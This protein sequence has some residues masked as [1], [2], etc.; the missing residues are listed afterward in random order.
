MKSIKNWDNKTWLSSKDY[1]NSFNKF[2]IKH[3]NLNSSSKILDIGCGRGKILGNLS[4]KLK[5]KNR[6]IGID[7]ESHKDK[8]KKIFFKK[9]DGINFFKANNKR[10]DLIL[11]KQTIHLLKMSE[12]KKLIKFCKNNLLPEGQIF[13]FTLDPVKNEIPTF[14][15][16]HQKLQYS[17][18]KDKKIINFIIKNNKCIS[19]KFI[20][21]VKVKKQ[22][23]L[24]MVKDKYISTLL[25]FNL[26][27]IEKGCEEIRLKFKNEINFRDKL[28]CVVIKK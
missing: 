2:L 17:L 23:Y 20:Y 4:T 25:D 9:I 15:K 1:I 5:L 16:M 3:S 6:P 11:I 19:K 10:F 27:D 13:I 18:N 26:K 7:I 24:K 14:K 22:K 12:I 8:D 21:K 28:R